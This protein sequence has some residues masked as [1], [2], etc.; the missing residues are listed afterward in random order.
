MDDL[1]GVVALWTFDAAVDDWILVA[2]GAGSISG[3]SGD[4]DLEHVAWEP[5]DLVRYVNVLTF[6][7][8]V[9]LGSFFAYR[10]VIVTTEPC[11]LTTTSTTTET[12]TTETTTTTASTETTTTE[13]TT[14]TTTSSTTTSTTTSTSTSTTTSTTTTTTTTTTSTTT[15][16]TPE[17]GSIFWWDGGV[18]LP[19]GFPSSGDPLPDWFDR[20]GSANDGIRLVDDSHAPTWQDAQVAFNNQPAARLTASGVEVSGSPNIS[21]LNTSTNVWTLFLVFR[22]QASHGSNA[23]DFPLCAYAIPT[24]SPAVVIGNV[25]TSGWAAAL[26]RVSGSSP[27]YVHNLVLTGLD[28]GE[29]IVTDAVDLDD[30]LA[31]L[32]VIV[33]SASAINVHVDGLSIY[34][35]SIT[36]ANYGA[37]TEKFIIGSSLG[38]TKGTGWPGGNIDDNF[39]GFVAEARLVASDDGGEVGTIESDLMSKYNITPLTT[40]TTTTTT[41]TSTSTTT[42]TTTTG[43]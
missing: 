23:N 19:S 15:T 29:S 33:K 14:T 25:S 24:G 21:Q 1:D 28:T 4:F 43:P 7:N 13:T 39:D 27:N 31:H 16:T 35:S 2:S 17:F 38:S 41:T 8:G 30:T 9:L 10:E 40:T 36:P 18:P 20:S 37:G 34:S 26:C 22:T 5:P 42:T 11:F 6:L 3:F 12:T 32:M